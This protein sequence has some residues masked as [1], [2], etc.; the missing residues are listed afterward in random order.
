MDMLRDGNN[1]Q[2]NQMI[3]QRAGNTTIALFFA[4]KS[5][6]FTA[7]VFGGMGLNFS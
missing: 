1:R 6:A 3:F 5:K 4:I 7:K 2:I